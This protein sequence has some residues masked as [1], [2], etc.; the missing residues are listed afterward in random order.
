MPDQKEI[1]LLQEAEVGSVIQDLNVNARNLES[2]G[3][4]NR[5]ASPV[6]V[7]LAAETSGLEA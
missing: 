1:F 2:R 3:L 4:L 5:A 7:S 6:V